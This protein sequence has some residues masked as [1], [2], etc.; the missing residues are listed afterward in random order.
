[1]APILLCKGAPAP[2]RV[3]ELTLRR[4]AAVR[5]EAQAQEEEVARRMAADPVHK[6]MV[7]LK[8]MEAGH[9]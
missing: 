4:E 5:A 6:G 9:L 8:A 3:W 2:F 1:M 7:L